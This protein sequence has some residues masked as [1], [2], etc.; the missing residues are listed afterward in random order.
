MF[1]TSSTSIVTAI[2]TREG[3]QRLADNS[4]QFKITDFKFSDDEINY[5]LYDGSS[6]DAPNTDI[7]NLPIL[8]PSSNGNGNSAQRFELLSLP[9]GTLNVA[10]IET[11][12][13]SI[14]RNR[15]GQTINFY[16]KTIRGNDSL[17][18]IKSSDPTI[19]SVDSSYIE[20]TNDPDKSQSLQKQSIAYTSLKIN[21]SGTVII[22][23]NGS[24]SKT[25]YKKEI[26]SINI[27]AVIEPEIPNIQPP[28]IGQQTSS[29]TA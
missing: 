6:E 8:E 13:Q 3:K 16:I 21:K 5:A 9:F 11:N 25:Y 28:N 17:Y 20:S 24:N 4:Q 18:Y 7:L 1:I 14:Y 19:I 26:S 23:I 2:L 22:E 12:L 29:L 10:Q 27:A 15:Q